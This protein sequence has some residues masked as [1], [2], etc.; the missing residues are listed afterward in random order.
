MRLC[1][2]CYGRYQ[3]EKKGFANRS[4][5]LQCGVLIQM[6]SQEGMGWNRDGVGNSGT[7]PSS[8]HHGPIHLAN[9]VAHRPPPALGDN[10]QDKRQCTAFATICQAQFLPPRG[11]TPP[12]RPWCLRI[13]RPQNTSDWVSV[14]RELDRI[15]QGAWRTLKAGHR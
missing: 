10:Q 3:D 5:K 6:Q 2:R 11:R 14:E 7:W 9:L 1:I 13:F 12:A 8:Q 15:T 4:R